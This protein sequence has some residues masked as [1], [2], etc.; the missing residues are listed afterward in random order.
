MVSSLTNL[1]LS[2]LFL[3]TTFHF[4]L[5]LNKHKNKKHEKLSIKI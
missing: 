3:V 1:G 2:I 5:A 4:W